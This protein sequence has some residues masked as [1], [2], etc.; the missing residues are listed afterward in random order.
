MASYSI[1]PASGVLAPVSDVAA[2]TF[3]VS[4]AADPSGSFVYVANQNSNNVT[5]YSVSAGG[6]L[7]LV[8]NSSIA[9]GSQ[10]TAIAVD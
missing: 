10:P 1:T 8:P 7:A 3:P 4:I 5:V 2:G 9:A 6:T